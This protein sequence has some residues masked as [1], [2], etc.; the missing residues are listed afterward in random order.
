[1]A[2]FNMNPRGL[3]QFLQPER[4]GAAVLEVGVGDDRYEVMF[5]RMDAPASHTE[6]PED[7]GPCSL[8]EVANVSSRFFIACLAAGAPE[9]KPKSF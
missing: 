5:R 4:D 2:H 8:E 9:V 3:E 7:G 1:M 6:T